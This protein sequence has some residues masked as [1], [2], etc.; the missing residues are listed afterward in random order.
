MHEIKNRLLLI[1]YWPRSGFSQSYFAGIRYKISHFHSRYC[2][3][4]LACL[5]LIFAI[6]QRFHELTGTVLTLIRYQQT[7][8]KEKDSLL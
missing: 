7:P 4:I 2:P 3:I 1:I 5:D 8:R 6:T